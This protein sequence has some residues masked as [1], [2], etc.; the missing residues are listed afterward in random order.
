MSIDLNPQITHVC[1]KATFSWV[2]NQNLN[3]QHVINVRDKFILY[4]HITGLVWESMLTDDDILLL[5]YCCFR[6]R[7]NN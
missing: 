7:L 5:L 2:K 6:A 3:S 1:T 4:F